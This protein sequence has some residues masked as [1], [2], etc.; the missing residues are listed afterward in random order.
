MVPDVFHDFFVASTGAG[1]ALVGLLFV[2]VS[3]APER[4][5]TTE[6]PVERRAVAFS[7]YTCLL[8]AFFLSLAALLPQANLG[9]AAL[10]LSAI[11]LANQC[12]LTWD[13]F[14]HVK[15]SWLSI[16]RGMVL[17]VAGFLLYGGEL[18][19]ALLLTLSPNNVA[20]ISTLADLLLGIY[21]LG[22]TRAWQLLG[23]RSHGLSE[24]LSPLHTS[25]GRQPQSTEDRSRSEDTERNWNTPLR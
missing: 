13:L 1:A 11:G 4:T 2:A 8:N 6:A 5:V 3:I 23:G 15:R 19:N 17:I 18:Y 25:E 9:L 20:V 16:V 24:W 22:L 21:A 12:F 14:R 7:A 10:V